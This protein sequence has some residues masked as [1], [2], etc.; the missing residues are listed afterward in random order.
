MSHFNF[1]FI[2]FEIL[3][4]DERFFR[5][6]YV[7]FSKNNDFFI[8]LGVVKAHM[9]KNNTKMVLIQV[10][11]IKKSHEISVEMKNCNKN[12]SQKYF[13]GWGGEGRGWG[14]LRIPNRVNSIWDGRGLSESPLVNF[15]FLARRAMKL[16]E[17]WYLLI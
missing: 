8:K 13:R 9:T 16:C 7:F 12:G 15:F 14:R 4:L 3:T 10:N 17:F 11:N 5:K 6:K 2:L 1:T